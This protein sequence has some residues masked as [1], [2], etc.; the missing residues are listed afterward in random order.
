MGKTLD[1]TDRPAADAAEATQRADRFIAELGD[2]RRDSSSRNAVLVRVGATLLVLG[3]VIAAIAAL[4]SQSTNNPLN[5]SSD[6]SLGLVGIAVGILGGALFLRYSIGQ[7]LRFWLLRLSYE[8]QR[9]A[10]RD[11]NAAPR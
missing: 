5:Q 10:S 8:Q 11:R 3:V 2:V 4:L 1:R 6:I 9:D 7:F